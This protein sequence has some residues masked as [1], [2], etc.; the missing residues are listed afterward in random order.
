MSFDTLIS[1]PVLFFGLGVLA[2]RMRS[3]LSLPE[4]ISKL[5][6]LYL[7]MAIG[8]KGGVQM[9][10]GGGWVIV[11]VILA[12]VALSAVMPFISFVALRA[13]SRLT[14]TDAAAIA[15]HYGSISIVTFVAASDMIAQ[16]SMTAGGYM[17]A[18]AAA[19]EAP[20]IL[21][22]LILA[23]MGQGQ[24][25]QVASL[26]AA[27][28]PPEEGRGSVIRHALTN[29]SIVLLCG[30]FAIGWLTGDRG[31]AAVEP[32]F[33]D[34]F[35][36]VLCLFLLDMG[37]AAGRGL[38]ANGSR[39]ALPVLAHGLYMPIIGASLGLGAA[40][41]LGLG[42]GDTALL[43]TLA[44]SASYIAVPAALRLALPSAGLSV[45]LSLSL[46]VT[47]PFNITLGIPI[48]MAVAAAVAG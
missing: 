26:G 43:M 33:V 1:P 45:P 42:A 34:I 12:G 9:G 20:A 11:G 21:T 30:A 35:R 10:A 8:F 14:Q 16:S 44:A 19:M 4:S 13:S 17:V 15:A 29:G 46:G 23:R 5:L 24:G 6:S 28:A 18:V 37:L 36:G 41:L 39:T 38:S 27:V 7:I 3:D 22:G 47:F 48:Y 31:M 32:F 25:R 2:A 40:M